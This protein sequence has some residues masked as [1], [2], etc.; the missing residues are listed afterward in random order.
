MNDLIIMIGLPGSGKSYQAKQLAEQ[1]NATLL[2]SDDLRIEFGF[3]DNIKEDNEKL[4]EYIK[5]RALSEITVKNVIIDATNISSKNRKNMLQGFV[6]KCCIQGIVMATP[7]E[8]CLERNKNRDR[9]VPEKAINRMLFNFQMPHY[10]EGFDSINIVYPNSKLTKPLFDLLKKYGKINQ[11]NPHHT[12]TIFE[13]CVKARDILV[14]T[15][16]NSMQLREAVLFHDFGKIYA[17]TFIN[18]K[19]EQTETAHY[20]NHENISAY[21][22]LTHE[23]HMFPNNFTLETVNLIQYHMLLHDEHVKIDKLEKKFGK[24]FVNKLKIINECDCDAR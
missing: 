13:H 21:Y 18:R 12:L 6:G 24:E 22:Y 4:F 15:E 17:K 1:Y 14:Q 9:I 2:S 11:D 5:Q 7:Y 20:Y 16:Y 19:G 23:S 10:F 8:L 3:K